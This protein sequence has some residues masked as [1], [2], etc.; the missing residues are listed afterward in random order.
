MR[1]FLEN[2]PAETPLPSIMVLRTA[3]KAI[4]EQLHSHAVFARLMGGEINRPHY[5][6]LLLALYGFH[7]S[8][9]NVS[10]D[11]PLRCAQLIDDLTFLSPERLE[12]DQAPCLPQSE[13]LCG[14]ARWGVEYVLTGAS[15]GGKLLARK[16]DHLLGAETRDGRSFFIGYGENGGRRWRDF[17]TALNAG[18][19]TKLDQRIAAEAASQTFERFE[20]WMNVAVAEKADGEN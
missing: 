17:V 10:A 16:L 6:A 5:S 8:Y 12:V 19:P 15:L 3:T 14:S 11:G 20:A 2:R 13:A 4:H 9:Q 1:L 7:K 18:L